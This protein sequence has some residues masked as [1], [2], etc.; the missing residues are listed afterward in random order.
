MFAAFAGIYYWF[1]KITGRKMSEFWG[2]VHFWPTLI[3]MNGIFM[4]MMIQGLAGV[5]RRLYD[6]GLSYAHAQPVLHWNEFMSVCAWIMGLAQIPFIINLLWSI[7]SGQKVSDNPWEATTLEWDT[8]SPPGHGNFTHPVAACRGPY[9]YSVPGA[10]KDYS[11]QYQ[12][13]V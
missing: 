13:E 1:P 4:P 11:P 6:G 2:H 5:S 8:S 7:K 10:P 9:E 3:C 12:K